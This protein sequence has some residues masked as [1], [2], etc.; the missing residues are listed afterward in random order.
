MSL[1]ISLP[2]LSLS[3]S[4]SLYLS[5]SISLSVLS[6]LCSLSF[7]PLSLYALS[8]CSLYLSHLL[9]IYLSLSALSLSLSRSFSLLSY[10]LFLLSLYLS[11][12][13][14]S[15]LCYLS[16]YGLIEYQSLSPDVCKWHGRGK[17]CRYD[18]FIEDTRPCNLLL[19]LSDQT[20][21]LMGQ[22]WNIIKFGVHRVGFET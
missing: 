8:L 21:F 11:I 9:L 7:C 14:L 22:V 5:L 2:S 19:L 13:L 15:L 1:S 17:N 20:W 10:M 6:L 4:L 12:S 18:I 16:V 3:L